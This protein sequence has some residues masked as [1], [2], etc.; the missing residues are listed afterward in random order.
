MFRKFIIYAFIVCIVYIAVVGYLGFGIR[1]DFLA[2]TFPSWPFLIN[3]AENCGY[4]MVLALFA[5]GIL[6][7]MLAFVFM[8]VMSFSIMVI[9]KLN[10]SFDDRKETRKT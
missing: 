7:G 3:C 4:K 9:R 5:N 6:V 1:D 10:R 2:L 8:G